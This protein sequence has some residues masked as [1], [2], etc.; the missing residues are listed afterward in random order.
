MSAAATFDF[1]RRLQLVS[2]RDVERL[3]DNFLAPARAFDAAD[4]GEHLL[5]P[6]EM[7]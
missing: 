4:L 1:T 5:F 6:R 3:D 7:T 2:D